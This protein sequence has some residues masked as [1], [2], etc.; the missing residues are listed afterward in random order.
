MK[1]IKKTID[2]ANLN[3]LLGAG[4]STPFLEILG[5]IE[6]DLTKAEKIID[7]DKKKKII[8]DLRKRYFTKSM[9]GN[10]KIIKNET[11]AYKDE[12]LEDYKN[13]Y[14][15]ING[16]L[17][18]RE[19]SIL[20]KQVNIFTTN[21]DIFSEI[22]LENT[23]IEFNDGFHG[24]FNPK[25]DLG[26]FKKSYYKKSLHYENTSEIP[27]FNILKLHG[28]LSWKENDKEI[29]LDRDLEL[30]ED[31]SKNLKN[32]SIFNELYKK[33]K[34]VNPTKNKFE[35]TV[36]GEH[37]YDLLRIYSNELEK[38]STVLFVIGFSFADEHIKKMTLRVA[39]SN[40]TLKIFI[41]SHSPDIDEELKTFLRSFYILSAD[42]I[43]SLKKEIED[44]FV[45]FQ[46]QI[47]FEWFKK[48]MNDILTQT[49]M[50]YL[51]IQESI[52]EYLNYIFIYDDMVNNTK[53][54]NI[55]IIY[56]K[57]IDCEVCNLKTITEKV[58][59]QCVVKN[60][61]NR[62]VVVEGEIKTEI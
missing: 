34:I 21:I 51:E 53:N 26:N 60:S 54:K 39:S 24:K 31:V 23:G 25:Y 13:F 4:V 17:L 9:F 2:S 33:L 32:E 52:N 61:P 1:K 43:Q 50:G 41:F 55:E 6:K 40:P 11:D 27:V 30:T 5:N 38:E 45:G 56:P 8:F 15:S 28:S 42:N 59:N 20:T 10:L 49:E 14:R 35:D 58:F 36:L 62:H 37:Y 3:F 47:D 18:Q 12:V 22:S 46:K 7:I 57:D 16:L 48:Y 29:F 19:N 44:K